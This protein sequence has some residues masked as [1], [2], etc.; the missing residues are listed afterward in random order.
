MKLYHPSWTFDQNGNL[1]GTAVIQEMLTLSANGGSY[2]GTAT[3]DEYD[4]SGNLL[5]HATATVSAT[6]ITV[7]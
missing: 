7:P 1:N 3:I 5:F 6:R 4:L 2:Q